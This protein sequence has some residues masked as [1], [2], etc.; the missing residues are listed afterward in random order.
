MRPVVMALSLLLLAG[1]GAAERPYVPQETRAAPPPRS[2]TA[3]PEQEVAEGPETVDLGGGLRARIEWPADPDPLL[4][5]M[6]DQYVGT[7]K[8]VARGQRI[9]KRGLE[10]D[11][12]VQASDWVES[13]AKVRWTMRGV[14]RLYNLRVIARMG[15]GAQINACVDESGIRLVS[16]RTGKAVS[17]QPE[18]LRTPYGQSVAAHRGDD[19]VWRI[20]TYV[21]SRERCTR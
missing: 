7:R 5:V 8:A 1:C 16:S 10:L 17:P 13:F 19:G 20:R 2:A 15:K 14:G 6:V 4:Q 12:A 3:A 9:Y 18:W 11:A 21:T